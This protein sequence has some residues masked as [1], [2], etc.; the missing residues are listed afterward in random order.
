M[1]LTRRPPP[2]VT[3]EERIWLCLVCLEVAGWAATYDRADR[4]ARAHL[5][6]HHPSWHPLD[7]VRIFTRPENARPVPGGPDNAANIDRRLRV[8]RSQYL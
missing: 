3:G 8:V 5:A 7:G 1:R 6:R 4:D 2:A